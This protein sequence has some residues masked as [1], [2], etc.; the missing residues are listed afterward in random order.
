MS[1]ETPHLTIP[2]GADDHA[3]GA[4]DA[5]ITLVEFGD[6]ECPHCG[7]AYPIVKRVQKALGK[8]LR[9]VFRNMP[10]TQVH[11][12][13][14]LAAESAEAAGAQGQFWAMH[15]ALFEHQRTLG[16]ELVVRLAQQLGLDVPRFEKD[17]ND[18][19][20][21]DRVRRDFNGGVRSGVDGTPTFYVNGERFDADWEDDKAFAEGI[22][23]MV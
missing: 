5:P 3:Q 9:F 1:V 11:P 13:A 16:P 20:F 12:H 8:R 22:L 23:A 21:R 2:V 17:V 10:L 6:Y 19:R 4:A 15:D 7:R 18:G 14:E